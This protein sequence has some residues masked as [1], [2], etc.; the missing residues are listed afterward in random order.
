M[1]YHL[2]LIG[3]QVDMAVHVIVVESADPSCTQPK[4]LGCDIQTMANGAGFKMYIAVPSVSEY[5][6][7]AREIADHRKAQASVA[8]QSLSEAQ[9]SGDQAL[10]ASLHKLQLGTLRPQFVD[11]GLYAIDAVSVHIK[12]DKTR[13]GEVN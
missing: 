6:S 10:V 9:G 7:G 1:T 11:A 8:S 3:R 2:S 5:G 12:L 4:C 13:V